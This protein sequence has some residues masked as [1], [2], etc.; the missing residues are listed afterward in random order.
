[1]QVPNWTLPFGR[2][3][4]VLLLF[5]NKEHRGAN[6]AAGR[7]TLATR[8]NKHE[9]DVVC[10]E[11]GAMFNCQPSQG[12]MVPQRAHFVFDSSQV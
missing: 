2:P 10:T 12:Q 1:M 5:S 8:T 6:V 4:H 3:M 9:E 7:Y 11:P